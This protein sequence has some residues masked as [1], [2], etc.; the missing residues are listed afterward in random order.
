MKRRHL[1]IYLGI[2]VILDILSMILFVLDK[3][4]IYYRWPF[5]LFII[6]SII[7]ISTLV[8]LLVYSKKHNISDSTLNVAEWFRFLSMSMM[9]ILMIFMFFITSATVSQSSMYPTLEDGQHVLIYHYDYEPQRGDIVIV[10]VTKEQYVNHIGDQDYYV[11]RVYGMPGDLV[12]FEFKA[13]NEYYIIINGERIENPYGDPYIASYNIATS[14]IN[15]VNYDERDVIQ[16]SL[17]MQGYIK[18]DMYLVFGDNVEFSVDSRDLGAIHKIDVVG[19]VIFR[20]T[21][22][23]SLNMRITH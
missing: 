3:S 21:P 14:N 18:D 6:S 22:F 9:I 15:L 11:K 19:K 7:A 10:N 5:T 1:Y 12:T 20:I 2:S 16:A 13:V 23:S 4:P 8:L 17:D